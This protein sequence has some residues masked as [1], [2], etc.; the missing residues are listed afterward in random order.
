MMELQ[1]S[2]GVSSY[3]LDP[4][5]RRSRIGLV[6]LAVILSLFLADPN[7]SVFMAV[8]G[9][10]G[11]VESSM[12]VYVVTAAMLA[13]E[14]GLFLLAIAFSS[15]VEQICFEESWPAWIAC[16]SGLAGLAVMILYQ[17]ISHVVSEALGLCILATV[18]CLWAVRSAAT[19]LYLGVRISCFKLPDIGFLAG[20]TGCLYAIFGLIRV[21]FESG[22]VLLMVLGCLAMLFA[23]ALLARLPKE[24]LDEEAKDSV[25]A[26]QK[27]LMSLF[28]LASLLGFIASLLP[29][30]FSNPILGGISK[31]ESVFIFYVGLIVLIALAALF[32]LVPLSRKSISLSFGFCVMVFIL[33]FFSATFI[34]SSGV[35]E[36]G[37]GV[38]KAN[39][40]IFQVFLFALVMLMVKVERLKPV[41][42]ISLFAIF[43]LDFTLFI[44]NLVIKPLNFA[45]SFYLSQEYLIPTTVVIACLVV[46]VSFLM[47]LSDSFHAKKSIVVDADEYEQM[48]CEAASAGIN[49]TP[50]EFDILINLHK[51]YSVK[52]I[53]SILFISASTVQSHVVN[54]YKKM[55]VHSKQELIDKIDETTI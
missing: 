19:L 55:D 3:W 14:M 10:D 5:K 51:G 8:F 30:V 36:Y 12:F 25:K 11:T 42:A 27:G 45:Y 17:Q 1:H 49:L 39:Q 34:F 32:N 28:F 47:I 40:T 54:I 37:T 18:L 22:P 4:V 2:K 6:L 24:E 46:I 44:V 26:P 13:L 31:N 9:A 52:K 20:A 43:A 23:P 29:H 33:S 38:I 21:S 50:R 16:F 48:L 35:S 15:K 53:A 41:T 7:F